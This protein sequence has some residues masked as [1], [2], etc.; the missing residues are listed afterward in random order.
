MMFRY[1]TVSFRRVPGV[2]RGKFTSIDSRL[3]G[4]HSSSTF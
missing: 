3:G 2:G 1:F 4:S